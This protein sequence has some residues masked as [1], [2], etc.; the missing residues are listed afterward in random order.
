MTD[1][2]H[3]EF[4]TRNH[5]WID[6][7]IA[8]LHNIAYTSGLDEQ[9]KIR[10]EVSDSGL[11]VFYSEPDQ[12]KQF[13][14]ACYEELAGRYWNVSTKNQIEEPKAVFYDSEQDM[15]LLRPKR[16]PTPIPDLF[17]KGSSWRLPHDDAGIAFDDLPSSMRARVEAFLKDN[18]VQLWGSKKRILLKEA[19]VC[20]KAID[21]FPQEKKNKSICSICG[22]KSSSCSSVS[23]PTFMLFAS[24]S[25][26]KC[27]NSQAGAPDKVCWECEMLGRFA[28]DSAGYRKLFDDLFILQVNSPNLSKLINANKR[29]GYAS[30]LRDVDTE[31]YLCNLRRDNGSL[32]T[33]AKDSYEFLWSFFVQAFGIIKENQD[34]ENSSSLLDIIFDFTL[35][36]A[37]VNI[38]LLVVNKKGQTFNTKELIFYN[39]VAY[40]FR[41]LNVLEEEKVDP[42]LLFNSLYVRDEDDR[43]SRF[44]NVFFKKVLLKRSVLLDCEGFASH[45]TMTG[46]GPYLHEILRFLVKYEPSIGGIKMTPQEVEVAVN[47]GKSIVLQAREKLDNDEIKKIKGDLFTLRKS[48]SKGDFLNSLNTLQMRY[49]LILSHMIED[50]ILEGV[51]FEEFKAYCIIGALNTFNGISRPKK[52]EGGNN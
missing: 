43:Y 42:R 23:Q 35:S 37:P 14:N 21:V 34:T 4:K 3:Y 31:N 1:V 18:G 48:R 16:K 7:G 26:T 5:W 47:L 52:I 44:R 49:G 41:L 33:Y 20:H 22:R 9:Y 11:E 8:G 38:I 30:L 46:K 12:L 17:T 24:D 2:K 10:L 25:A 13:I 32:I 28:V 45:L 15:L 19:P 39:D 40:A 6:A 27:F 29:I 50:G 51:P 36:K